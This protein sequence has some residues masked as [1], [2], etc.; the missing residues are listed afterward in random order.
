V[1]VALFAVVLVGAVPLGLARVE[2]GNCAIDRRLRRLRPFTWPAAVALALAM[3]MAPGPI[4]AALATP[5]LLLGAGFGLAA[6]LALLR[7]P[8]RWRP[9]RRL[10]VDL[11]LGFLA[12]GSANA[13]LFAAGLA[14]LGFPPTI[15]LLTAVHFHA[16]GFVLMTAGILAYHRRPSIVAGS[17]IGGLAIGTIVTAAGFVGVPGAAVAGAVIVAAGGLLIG[18]ATIRV[19]A[20]LDRRP[21]RWLTTLAGGA[22]FVSMP[23]AIAWAVGTQLGAP[24]FA[25]DLMVRTHG[26]I[27][28][29][30]VAVPA[31]IGWALE[32]G[33]GRA[34]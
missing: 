17:G 7:D 10:A 25:L 9:N 32:A 28:A 33:A 12:F 19:S 20:T 22:L 13:W 31:M 27:N 34:R 30:A 26:T 2:V 18:V 14:P 23:L 8:A 4:A 5:W 29:V 6:I 21:A 15:V 11:S 1:I 24:P 3:L 16:A